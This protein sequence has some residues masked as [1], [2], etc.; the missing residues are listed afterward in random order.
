MISLCTCYCVVCVFMY[1]HV[2]EHMRIYVH[3][4]TKAQ[5]LIYSSITVYTPGFRKQPLTDP[6]DSQQ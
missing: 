1:A 6:G 5:Y 2:C 4:E 3:V